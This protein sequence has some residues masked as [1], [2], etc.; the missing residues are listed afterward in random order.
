MPTR[1]LT[2]ATGLICL[3]VAAFAPA[4]ATW[5]AP[6]EPEDAVEATLQVDSSARV[7]ADGWTVSWRVRI[8]CPR[9]V[10]IK[11]EALLAERDPVAI[12]QLAGED[13]GIAATVELDGSE[14]CTG[15]RQVLR[16]ELEVGNTVVRDLG[17]GDLLTFREPIRPTPSARTS[18]AIELFSSEI[19]ELG[20]FFVQYCAAPNCASESGPRITLT[21]AVSRPT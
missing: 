8:T 14:R 10:R 5:L 2:L 7:S 1:N 4:V 15:R 19:P 16:L 6:A 20:G 3:T 9:G 18:A 17:T 12:P 11:G 13:Q 21:G